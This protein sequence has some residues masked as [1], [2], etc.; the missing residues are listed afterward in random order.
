MG[1]AG[2]RHRVLREWPRP[3]APRPV[4]G[5]RGAASPAAGGGGGHREGAAGSAATCCRCS[6][7]GGSARG[8]PRSRSFPPR[9]AGAARPCRLLPQLR[10]FPAEPGPVPGLSRRGLLPG[11]PPAARRC[12]DDGAGEPRAAAGARRTRGAPDPRRR[13]GTGWLRAGGA[14][15]MPGPAL[16]GVP[17]GGSGSP[18]TREQPGGFPGAR[19]ATG[20]QGRDSFCF[21]LLGPAICQDI[22]PSP[23]LFS[24]EG[25]SRPALRR[26][27]TPGLGT[28][29]SGRPEPGGAGLPGTGGERRGRAGE[30]GAGLPSPP[31]PHLPPHPPPAEPGAAPQQ[32]ARGGSASGKHRGARG[33][34]G[35]G[36]KPPECRGAA[37]GT[38]GGGPGV[39]S[40]AASR[41]MGQEEERGVWWG[42]ALSAFIHL[43]SNQ[44]M[45]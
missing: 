11:S 14:R 19:G 42:A 29:G 40:D 36:Q 37:L 1:R 27:G 39:F 12:R 2:T 23:S 30:P 33:G 44:A 13:H 34:P 9:P 31:P 20:V 7:P 25:G 5:G 6:A 26:E 4:T 43:G 38:Q 35:G 22:S 18:R 8:S 41:G 10:E 28:E 21:A 45:G 17:G 24:Q 15:G 16:G 32:A 3:P